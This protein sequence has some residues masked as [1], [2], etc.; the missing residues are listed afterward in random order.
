MGDWLSWFGDQASN[1]STATIIAWL[2][3]LV[4][5]LVA[6]FIYLYNL[7]VAVFQFFVGLAKTVGQFFATL[8]NDFFKGIF[9]SLWNAIV[10]VHDW[11][12]GILQPIV[13]FLKA[14]LKWMNLIFKTYIQ[15]FLKVL[16]IVR[17]F[18]N[19]LRTFG[20]KWAGELDA[21]L[22]KI[23]NDI[24]QAFQKAVGYINAVIGI[25]NSLADPLGLF[26]RPTFVM[27]MRRI[28]PSFMRGVSG[29]PLGYFF[30]QPGK[31]APAGMGAPPF[32]LNLNNTTQ[33]P[34]PS[35]YLNDDDGLEN[36]DGWDGTDPLADDSMDSMT[37]LDY[38]TSD[39][40]YDNAPDDPVAA[41]DALQLAAWAGITS[42]QQ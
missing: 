4:S 5:A 41:L 31:G 33:N 15:P 1:I 29:M 28:F 10:K 20:I 21:W 23:Q 40:W 39:A 26:R 13:N 34:P 24:I 6:V 16:S 36:F 37:G 19:V 35:G 2:E 12:E 7:L 42:T 18:L 3:W 17:G 27:S 25:V 38:F 9:Q 22:G 32:P 8:W 30:P 14:A 11:L